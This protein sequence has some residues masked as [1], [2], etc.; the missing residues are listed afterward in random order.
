MEHQHPKIVNHRTIIKDAIN[1]VNQ[2]PPINYT[3]APVTTS[4]NSPKPLFEFKN[5]EIN[6]GQMQGGSKFDCEFILINTDERDIVIVS[7]K[8]TCGCTTPVFSNEPIKP[9]ES[10]TIKTTYQSQ[11]KGS[12]NK[13]INVTINYA[14]IQENMA[15]TD[16]Q[17]NLTQV[18]ETLHIKGTLV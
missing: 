6:F 8:P 14:M 11:G 3:N 13:S 18:V 1:K 15:L 12:V 7:A 9:G 16:D 17:K 4:N 10:T 5:K 2:R